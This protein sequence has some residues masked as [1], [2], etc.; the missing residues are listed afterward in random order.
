MKY[1]LCVIAICIQAMTAVH[2]ADVDVLLIKPID[3]LPDSPE[4]QMLTVEYAPGE[5]SVTH[6][7]NAHTFVYVLEGGVEMQV[8]G[9]PLVQLAAGGTFYELPEDT[10]VVS[11]NASDETSAKFLVFF[12]KSAG[13]PTTVPVE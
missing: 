4:V 10:H 8:A 3:V 5:A 2:A 7:H 13:A 11:R 12:I 1:F 6:R 9:G